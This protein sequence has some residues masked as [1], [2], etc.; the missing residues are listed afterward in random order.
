MLCEIMRVP[1]SVANSAG[2]ERS[3]KLTEVIGQYLSNY[4]T[5]SQAL[6]ELLVSLENQ[7]YCLTGAGEHAEAIS[8]D[9]A[10]PVQVKEIK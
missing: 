10:V 7:I 2:S 4:S 6:T 1:H 9:Q 5:I 8:A 3:F